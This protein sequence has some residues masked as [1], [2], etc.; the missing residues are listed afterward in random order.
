MTGR[1][2]IWMPFYP[3]DYLRDTGHLTT[4]QHGA[5][6]LA[7]FHYWA[8][9]RPLP[10]DDGQLSMITRL[11]PEGWQRDGHIV[12]TFFEARDGVLYHK[13]VEAELARA[14]TKRQSLSERGRRGAAARWSDATA[15][16]RS[17]ATANAQAM[18]GDAPS[19]SP[20]LSKDKEAS[21]QPPKNIGAV[22]FNECRS[23]LQGC[24]IEERKARALLGKWRKA[25]GDEA[26]DGA[27]RAAQRNAASDAVP[28]IEATLQ[29][30]SRSR[31][32]AAI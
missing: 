2:G 27:I 15:N 3:G 26:V 9:A 12:R 30:K 11:G 1:V 14:R 25:H 22:I 7:L 13:R 31:R 17:N 29:G 16:G 32:E 23:Y 24:G 4:E 19:P 21:P 28:Y 18:L 8:T 10:D 5:Y 20:S 6:L